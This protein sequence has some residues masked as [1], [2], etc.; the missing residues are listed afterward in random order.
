MHFTQVHGHTA[1]GVEST[2][3]FIAICQDMGTTSCK[4]YKSE[5]ELFL[6]PWLHTLM[7]FNKKILDLIKYG[8]N[9]HRSIVN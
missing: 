1:E 8:D 5:R 7:N 9:K 6:L 4:F 2:R 3:S